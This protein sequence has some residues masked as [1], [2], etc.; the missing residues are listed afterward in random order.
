MNKFSIKGRL[1]RQGLFAAITVAII[2]VGLVL[3]VLFAYLGQSKMIFADLTPEG[4]YTLTDRMKEECAFV[5]EM[6]DGDKHVKIL[7]CNDPDY[8]LDSMVTRLPYFTASALSNEFDNIEIETVNVRLRPTAVA[9]YKT[10]SLSSIKPTDVIVSYGGSY[11]IVSADSFWTKDGDGNYWSYNGEYKIATLIKSLTAVERP[12]AYFVTNHGE[13]YYDV[14]NPESAGSLASAAFY[15]LLVA[16][17]L[18]VKTLDLSAVDEIPE[19]CVL[20]I[21]NN[22]RTDFTYDE[23]KLTNLYHYTETDKIDKYLVRREGAIMVAKDYAI[24]LPTLEQFMHEWGIDFSNSLVKDEVTSGGA[25]STTNNDGVTGTDLIGVYDTDTES[26]GY[27]IY[28]DYASLSSAPRFIISNTGYITCSYDEATQVFESGSS[29]TYR[30]YATFFKTS[31]N[32]KAYSKNSEGVYDGTVLDAGKGV[33]DVAAVIARSYTDSHTSETT[34]SYVFAVNSPDF[35]ANETV[36]NAS[37]ANYDVLSSLITNMSRIDTYAS[38]DLGGISLNS[39]SYGGKRLADT[40]L[41]EVNT[42]VYSP[43]ASE[44]VKTNRGI[45]SAEIVILSVIA[46]ILPVAALVVGIVIRIKRKFL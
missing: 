11:R 12:S 21:I 17:G 1:G 20:L 4:L 38:I 29:Y 22:P 33:K 32:A 43:D 40:N 6:D 9:E 16:R 24:E 35:F 37:Y 30:D 19:D 3:N 45:G 27:A 28:G 2:V 46:F 23:D 10:T 8:L 26:Y 42:E 34:H 44:V 41:Y 15:D 5:D 7:F 18:A 14:E 25:I 31:E 36:G 39:S 13:T